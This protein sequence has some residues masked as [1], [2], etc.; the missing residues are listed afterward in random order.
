MKKFA[1]FL[2]LLC[3]GAGFVAACSD[4]DES[5]GSNELEQ[6]Y[7]S[8]EN[9]T[10][11]DG[12]MPSATSEE[13]IGGLTVNE[14]ALTGGMNFITILSEEEYEKFYVGVK[15]VNGY[16]EYAPAATTA[17]VKK[18]ADGVEYFSYTIP[19]M[20]SVNYNNDIVML[21]SAITMDGYILRPFEAEVK[22]VDSQ[23]GDLNLN[24]T[25][26]N[27]KDIDLHLILPDGTRIY[28]GN[29]GW[30]EQV[31]ED[32]V[33][34]IGL[35][36]D[37][38]AACN[39][40]GLKNENIYFPEEYLQDGTYTVIVDMYSNCDRTIATSWSVVARYKGNII[41]PDTGKNPV[42]GVYPVNAPNGDMTQVMTFTLTGVEKETGA[43]R[44][45]V[46]A[47][48][49][50]PRTFMDEAKLSEAMIRPNFK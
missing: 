23:S 15:G 48:K 29:R 43:A 2:A 10:Y 49:K 45:R 30:T 11:H 35:D 1:F 14:Q 42:T 4:D 46:S 18:R 50:R 25:F 37:S 20:Y 3:A 31:S 5:G 19:V 26:S 38:N 13:T 32:S 33:R 21:I 6:K 47:L 39:I 28:Y 36:H 27:E 9:A 24:L 40:D 16:F 34:T 7:F 41:T 17:S 12:S 44:K 22:H 8:I